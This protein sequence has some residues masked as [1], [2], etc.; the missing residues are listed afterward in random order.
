MTLVLR[1]VIHSAPTTLKWIV[2][3]KS[4]YVFRA[5]GCDGHSY[6]MNIC[7][8]TVLVDGLPPSTLPLQ[9]TSDE[10]YQRVFG[11]T[12]FE[13]IKKGEWMETVQP[14][15]GRL[16]RF[17]IASDDILFIEE[18]PDINNLAQESIPW[19][20]SL[21][22]LHVHEAN[23]W[24]KELPKKLKVSYSHWLS[25]EQN[26]IFFR[27]MDFRKRFVH[28]T[29]NLEDCYKG[30]YPPGD[31][32]TSKG[33]TSIDRIMIHRA[34]HMNDQKPSILDILERVESR[35]FIHIFYRENSFTNIKSIHFDLYRLGLTFS[36]NEGDD[37]IKCLEIVGYKL[38]PNQ[39]LDGVF[40]GF[41]KYLVLEQISDSSIKKIVIPFGKI[42]R[43]QDE[44]MLVGIDVLS[45]DLCPV[46]DHVEKEI[47]VFQYNIH[48]RWKNFLST[49]I[50]GRLFLACLFAA[51]TCAI[52]DTMLGMTG[53]EQAMILLRECHLNRPL[54][55][56]EALALSN[57]MDLCRGVSAALLLLSHDLEL[58]TQDF[59]FLHPSFYNSRSSL[60]L[61]IDTL[62]DAKSAYKSNLDTVSS[63]LLL[64][65][66]ESMRLLGGLSSLSL[67]KKSHLISPKYDLVEMAFIES[68]VRQHYDDIENLGTK[69]MS[70]AEAEDF[71]I[72]SEAKTQI[73]NEVYQD[74]H[75]SFE[76][77]NERVERNPIDV[78][79][80]IPK[81][82]TITKG[83]DD[84]IKKL[85]TYFK[86][87]LLGIDYPTSGVC[88]MSLSNCYR[89]LCNN[90][91]SVTKRELLKIAYNI[92]F[93][94]TF[95]PLLSQNA[96]GL[97]H[98]YILLWLELCV[99]QDK[100]TLLLL[101]ASDE[102]RHNE[103]TKELYSNRSWSVRDH[104][105]WLVFEAE[106]GIRIRPEQ[107]EI[108]NHLIH[109]NG[110]IV[111]LNCGLGKTRVILPML[112]LSFS[113][114][115]KLD[116]I[117]R[118][119]ILNTLLTEFCEYFE[120]ALG[121]SVMNIKLYTM[122]FRRDVEISGQIIESL[123]NIIH[124]CQYDRGCFIVAPE[125][126]LSME[127]KVKELALENNLDL[128]ERLSNVL[129]LSRWQNIFDEVDE[130][131]HYR[132][133]LIYS[134]GSVEPLPQMKHRWL[135]AE[136]LMHILYTRDIGIDGLSVRSQDLHKEACPF[137]V[138]EEVSYDL[139]REKMTD[140]V[141]TNPPLF[142]DWIKGHSRKADMMQVI[143]NPAA[144]PAILEDKLSEDHVYQLL[145]F[146]GL[147]AFDLLINCLKKRYRVDFGIRQGNKKQLA[148]PFRGAD[149]PSERSEYSHPDV[150]VILSIISYY[151]RG[152][153]LEQFKYSLEAMT[154]KGK[155]FQQNTYD[156]WLQRSL[157]R[158]HPET[159]PGINKFDKIDL[160]NKV[161]LDILYNYFRLNP[162]TI[163]FWLNTF[164]FPRD[165]DQ[166][167]HRLVGTPWH[168]AAHDGGFA[169]GFSGTNDLHLV[170]PLQMKQH[171]PWNTTDPI[172]CDILAT[173]G[174]MLD[175]IIR[176]TKK[177]N[178]LDDGSPS[179]MLLQFIL[180]N[181]D[182]LHALID[183]GALLVGVS[184]EDIALSIQEHI[185]TNSNKLQGV[186]FY[187]DQRREWMVLEKSGRCVPKFQSSFEEK[188]TF[189]IFDEP[190]CR[191]V[192]MKLRPDAVA[193]LTI[194][195]DLTK[196]K[197]MQAAGRMRKLHDS[198]SLEIVLEKRLHNEMKGQ[199]VRK[200]SEGITMLLEWIIQ[201]TVHS[202]V[203]GLPIWSEHGIFY[204]TSKKAVHSVLDD[205]S[206]LRSFY[207][208][209]VKK[210]D[211]SNSASLSKKYHFE[212]TGKVA[213]RKALLNINPI[214]DRCE[215][216]GEGYNTIITATDEECERELQR[217][218]EVEEEEEVEIS[219]QHPFSEKDWDYMKI[220][221]CN[222]VSELSIEVVP[223]GKMLEENLSIGSEIRAI[224]WPTNLHCTTNFTKTILVNDGSPV[225][226][227]LRIPD[228]FV[229]FPSNEVLLL[230]DREGAK[231]CDIFLDQKNSG[232]SSNYF[233]GHFAYESD[234]NS[235]NTML[236][237][238][239][240]P[241]ANIPLS[242]DKVCSMKLFNGETNY[243][244]SQKETMKGLLSIKKAVGGIV[245]AFVNARE[246]GKNME[247]SCLEKICNELALELE[248]Q[249]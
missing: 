105:Y 214:L 140:L 231:I 38:A 148:V 129:N 79:T 126:R 92:D 209:P 9:I 14:V 117:P 74:L 235:N 85:E 184:C 164:V 96:K 234:P 152:L 207:G 7:T 168:L 91:P 182:S 58:S 238:D 170:L 104:P 101:C 247:L 3:K 41:S 112:I 123:E 115:T 206:D 217:E 119:H 134:I 8:G 156:C 191:G 29:H 60:H 189:V 227:Y 208:K 171:L 102:Q 172:W 226:N 194:G 88:N 211:L 122:P 188:D 236:R 35:A 141:F 80:T 133:Q 135:A 110:S 39:H 190:R 81:L 106:Q 45:H 62:N 121:A 136:A 118:I 28:F 87:A 160:T 57:F 222:D 2:D 128:S 1:H 25:R 181:I 48:P 108:V 18:S 218:V 229:Q 162:E 143:S 158:I 210:D 19:T 196:D 78:K 220:F 52:P 26:L 132:Y 90:L 242:S 5:T 95:N 51:T 63:R 183:C 216:L 65:P 55:P 89:R 120:I 15:E 116:R 54:N 159:L 223:Y 77:Y 199:N 165:L 94:N 244:S 99:L 176:K 100:C 114:N 147:L 149:T 180:E 13:I 166:Y 44:K 200:V 109:S 4:K 174:K 179:E 186:T 230:S 173:N 198:Q 24:G 157:S 84:L 203:K 20:D 212:R 243:P 154:K 50:A 178:L 12:I 151:N 21:E 249:D 124:R 137:F 197:F 138:V 167:P 97:L 42:Y 11:K 83:I 27:C 201:N 127:M 68:T 185:S 205:K 113:Q 98:K 239:L 144:D 125:H 22:L 142:C 155:S 31:A 37:V 82:E 56:L 70:Q 246:K 177:V 130:I 93:A 204:E 163:N 221:S 30:K 111:Q 86:R 32:D 34:S 64:T 75:Q 67:K 53:E 145:A 193:A 213:T 232:F 175:T 195:Q 72:H 6:S 241:V 131:L 228:C 215:K 49:S 153:S 107:Y 33:S 139:F 248:E 46:S 225:D 23:M 237:C 43:S 61:E 245:E 103:F 187:D 161:Q 66:A 192:D 76:L 202:V 40:P 150:A 47:H 169:I 59:N 233:F 219:K 240:N 16:Y 36:I 71:P 10:R 73:E 69:Q 224:K 146:R 17:R